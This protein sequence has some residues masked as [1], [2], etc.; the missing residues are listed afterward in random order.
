MK[1]KAERKAGKAEKSGKLVKPSACE[2]CGFIG[3]LEKHHE[4]YSKP[5][6]V[7]W[8]C[9]K[10]HGETRRKDYADIIP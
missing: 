4:D 6:D 8:L 2:K 10:C 3:R 5:L 9:S 1:I 7:K